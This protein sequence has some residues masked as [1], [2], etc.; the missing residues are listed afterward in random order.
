VG[1]STPGH[2]RLQPAGE[3]NRQRARRIFQRTIAGRMPGS[4]RLTTPNARSKLGDNIITRV[5]LTH[6][7]AS[8][9]PAFLLSGPQGTGP[10]NP[11]YSR[12]RWVRNR[13]TLTA[14]PN[15]TYRWLAFR[16]LGQW[17][18]DDHLHQRL[19]TGPCAQPVPSAARLQTCRSCRMSFPPTHRPR[20]TISRRSPL[21]YP[22][23]GR[24]CPR[25]R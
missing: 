15:S 4:F 22:P 3:T 11:D 24:T 17:G 1:V 19:L 7:W 23:S 8:F 2:T 6:R 14:A 10:I 12:A 5:D 9:H 16:V 25:R 18:D 21:S 20:R 13:G